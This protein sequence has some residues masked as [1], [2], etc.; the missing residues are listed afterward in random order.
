[1]GQVKTPEECEDK[2]HK[3]LMERAF[4]TS[5]NLSAHFTDEEIAFASMALKSVKKFLETMWSLDSALRELKVKSKEKWSKNELVLSRMV[6]DLDADKLEAAI[7]RSK[8]EGKGRAKAA[9]E[10]A[11]MKKEARSKSVFKRTANARKMF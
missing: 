2:R 7:N 5:I 1:M 9:T 3:A 4:N 6:D 11:A 8:E 10:T